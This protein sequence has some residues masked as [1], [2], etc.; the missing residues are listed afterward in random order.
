MEIPVG[1]PSARLFFHGFF[2]FHF[3]VT[4]LWE[5]GAEKW[6]QYG[7]VVRVRLWEIASGYD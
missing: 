3:R 7:A 6:I 5:I 4:F 1:S 2:H